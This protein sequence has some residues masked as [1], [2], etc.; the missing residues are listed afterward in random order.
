VMN[1]KA[2]LELSINAIV[3]IVIAMAVLGLGLGF[4]RS[5]MKK[6]GETSTS[7]QEQIRGQILDDLRVGNK[8]LSF[9]TER[10]TVSF[11]ELKDFAV[12]IQNLEPTTLT[13]TIKLW[14]YK[15]TVFVPID[16]TSGGLDAGQFFWDSTLQ[17]LNG[18]EARVYGALFKA[19]NE[20]GNYLYKLEVVKDDETTIYDSKSFFVTVS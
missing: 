17:K 4:V 16:A 15:G 20:P 10:F 3:I 1:K 11:S 5:Q 12:G 7:V 18:G 6:I 2:A 8:K 19:K 14:E 9:P 13:F